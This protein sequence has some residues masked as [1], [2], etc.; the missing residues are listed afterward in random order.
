M[1]GLTCGC[2]PHGSAIASGDGKL[3]ALL[4]E[5]ACRLINADTFHSIE[6]RSGGPGMDTNVLLPHQ[7]GCRLFGFIEEAGWFWNSVAIAP[8]WHDEWG[9]VG[10]FQAASMNL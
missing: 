1:Q 7:C 5:E 4:P 8:A 3:L 6:G 2:W 9:L 10:I